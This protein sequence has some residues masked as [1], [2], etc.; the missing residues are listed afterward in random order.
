MLDL[1][2]PDI[3]SNRKNK[4]A[5]V[6]DIVVPM[7]HNLSNGEAE[8]TGKYENLALEVKNIWKLNN[9]FICTLVT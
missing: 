1:N 3:T 7:T 9:I 5:F 6:T 4:A 8:K 2:R